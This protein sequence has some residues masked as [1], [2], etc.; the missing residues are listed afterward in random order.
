MIKGVKEFCWCKYS[1]RLIGLGLFAVVLW[2]IDFS[3]LWKIVSESRVLQLSAVALLLFPYI[4]LKTA[5]WYSILRIQGIV[6]KPTEVIKVYLSGMFMGIITPGRIGDFVKVYYLKTDCSVPMGRGFSSVFIDRMLDL[7]FLLL[8]GSVG[9]LV[10]SIRGD[11]FQMLLLVF[12][13]A[14][15][16][17][18]IFIIRHPTKWL[19]RLLPRHIRE[20]GRDALDDF[21]DGFRQVMTPRFFITVLIS[22]G[23]FIIF[24]IQCFILARGLN[25]DIEFFKLSIYIAIMSIITLV[26]ISISG[27][28]TRDIALIY[29]FSIEGLPQETAVAYSFIYLM[30]FSVFTALLGLIGWYMKPMV[31][32]DKEEG[33]VSL[34]SSS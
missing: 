24:Y 22:V 20:R 21:S 7:G 25:I 11:I 14:L 16:G 27:I 2:R 10:F 33:T 8:T 12:A 31:K 5:R 17:T 29:F 23:V 18:G 9:G 26:P 15:L 30:L 4:G 19:S 13:L 34:T 32:V 3:Q 1:F 28:G 6:Y